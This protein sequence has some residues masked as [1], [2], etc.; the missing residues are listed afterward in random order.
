MQL[1]DRSWWGEEGEFYSICHNHSKRVAQCDS[2]GAALQHKEMTKQVEVFR[3]VEYEMCG[4]IN[5]F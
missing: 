3:Y 1:G 2:N 5:R 4:S